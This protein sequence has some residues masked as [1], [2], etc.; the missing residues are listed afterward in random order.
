LLVRS[1][2]LA[3]PAFVVFEGWEFV[4]MMS[5][6]FVAAAQTSADQMPWISAA[7]CPRFEH[8]EAWGSHFRDDRRRSKSGP[9]P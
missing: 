5:R 2:K 4:L 1:E 6:D 9:A 7:S 8:H 3:A